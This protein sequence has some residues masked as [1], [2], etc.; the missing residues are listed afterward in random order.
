MLGRWD[1]HPHELMGL[2]R[3]LGRGLGWF[4]C[5]RCSIGVVRRIGRR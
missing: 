4:G 1:C 5:V 3:G 2:G